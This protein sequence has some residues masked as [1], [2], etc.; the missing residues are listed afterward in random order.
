MTR[1][2]IALSPEFADW[3]PALLTA[4]ARGYLGVEVVTAS[5]DGQPLISMGGLKVLPDTDFAALEPAAFD[6]LVVPGGLAWEKGVA[7]DFG[8]L[9][10]RFHEDGRLVAGICAAASML[11]GT[12]LLDT[13]AHTG[14]GLASHQ[15]E[16]GYHGSAFYR[17]Q[18]QAVRDG[19]V[20][21]APGTAPFSFAVEILKGL[22]LWSAEAEA[23]LAGFAA[24]HRRPSA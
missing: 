13:V 1:I 4:A 22:D 12:G 24:E 11:A 7:P 16:P 3:E 19:Q 9:V 8:P 21:T 14:N 6:A 17:D 18:P 10:R 23:E 15:R 2:A 20:V 5:P